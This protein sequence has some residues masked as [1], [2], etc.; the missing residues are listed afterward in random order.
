MPFKQRMMLMVTAKLV[1]IGIWLSGWSDVHW[2]LYV[3]PVLFTLFSV[4]GVCPAT[5]KQKYFSAP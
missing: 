2:F 5:I 3:T 4:T 1:F